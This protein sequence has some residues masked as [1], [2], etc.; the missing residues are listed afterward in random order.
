MFHM[1]L[2][3]TSLKNIRGRAVLHD[4]KTNSGGAD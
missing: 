4:A 3:A 2:S 1:C